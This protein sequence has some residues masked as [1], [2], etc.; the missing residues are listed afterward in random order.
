MTL[1][2]RKFSRQD[3]ESV[4]LLWKDCGL[5]VPWNDPVRD[6]ER[7]MSMQPHLFL[8]GTMDDQVIASVMGGYDGHRGWIYY[9]AVHPDFQGRGFGRM[10]LGEIEQKL[11]RLDCPKINLM[12]RTA[13]HK[14]TQFY[15]TL[16]YSID[17]VTSLGKRLVQD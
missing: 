7:K 6:I 4:L 3:T 12:V 10:L 9:L 15:R 2:I 5:T 1:M 14:V 17:E 13:N 11:Q 16:G 8:V